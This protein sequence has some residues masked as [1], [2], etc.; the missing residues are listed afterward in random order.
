MK[1][2]GWHPNPGSTYVAVI[3]RNLHEMRC[4][5]CGG[6]EKAVGAVAAGKLRDQHLC[7]AGTPKAHPECPECGSQRSTC[8]DGVTARPTWH[9]SRIQLW[10]DAIGDQP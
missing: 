3:G 9:D 5:A 2:G 10:V 7:P 1:R 8:V 6:K 4:D